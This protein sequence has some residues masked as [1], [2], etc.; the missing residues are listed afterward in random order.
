MI[1]KN[2]SWNLV[3]IINDFNLDFQKNKE[4]IKLPNLLLRPI[5][6]LKLMGYILVSNPKTGSHKFYFKLFP[7]DTFLAFVL[8]YLLHWIAMRLL[9]HRMNTIKFDIKFIQ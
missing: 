2:N 9:I 5:T 6:V 8:K 3:Y 1:T 7:L 4:T